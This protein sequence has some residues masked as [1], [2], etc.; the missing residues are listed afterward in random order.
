[1][2]R[3]LKLR[4]KIL[5]A[6]IGISAIP[7]VLS[8]FIVF[9]LT[10]QQLQQ[11]MT[12]RVKAVA[13]YVESTTASSQRE[14]GN[15]VRLLA[16][17]SDLVDTVD[18]ARKTGDSVG[19][20]EVIN[21]ENRHFRFDLVEV[22]SDDGRMLFRTSFGKKVPSQTGRDY[23]VIRSSFKGEA[24]HDLGLF[25]G[26]LAIVAAAPVFNA[27]GRIGHLVG[28]NF[29]DAGY[30][31]RLKKLSGAEVAFFTGKGVYVATRSEL[32]GID[33]ASLRPAAAEGRAA[34]SKQLLRETQLDGT[35][36]AVV[37]S[38][39]GGRATEW[40]WPSARLS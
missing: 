23:P 32:L 38:S 30:A 19:L 35:P 18:F 25:D 1:M 34:G 11:D 17:D 40:F 36:F 15:T 27:Q 7:L 22:Y 16:H 9:H 24:A 2:F 12:A 29:L 14:L 26:Q 4:W 3:A 10:E 6:L 5:L 13:N 20:Q 37:T 39:L 33:P 28:V 31:R 21:D 8:A